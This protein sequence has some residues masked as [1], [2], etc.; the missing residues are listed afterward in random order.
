VAGLWLAGQINGTTGYE[1]AAAQ[2]LVAGLNAALAVLGR[3]PARFG[4]GDSYIGVMMDDLV[5]R[6]VT[7]PYRMFTS[8]A[9]FRLSLRAD[10]ADQRLTPRGLAWGCVGA[11]RAAAFA[12]KQTAL[13]AGRA[14]LA[15]LS[16]TPAEAARRGL[17]VNQDGQRRCGLDLLGASG[18]GFAQLAA[19]WPELEAIPPA[20]RNQ[21]AREQLYAR[22]L[23]RQSA[24]V[25]ALQRD[26]AVRFPESF[27]FDLPGLSTELRTK[28]ARQ[29]PE[30]LGQAGRI[31]GMTP[32][33]LTLLLARLRRRDRARTG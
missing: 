4:R 16:L 5:T 26:E 19:I 10:N 1:E 9:E 14:Q 2:G 30:T 24:D 25:A 21:I 29:R 23:D 33:A 7:E 22:Y 11:E 12:A 28:L 20:I 6:G 31:E 27:D 13:D 18:T 17:V 3:E 32:A 15:A 8:R